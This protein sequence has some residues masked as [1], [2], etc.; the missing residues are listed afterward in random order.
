MTS[1]HSQIS[2]SLW[3]AGI[4]ALA[5]IVISLGYGSGRMT[6]G[7][8]QQAIAEAKHYPSG[9]LS[10]VYERTS[11]EKNDFVHLRIDTTYR[12]IGKAA[13]NHQIV[14]ER[15]YSLREF[16]ADYADMSDAVG[17]LFV[18]GE[19]SHKWQQSAG[20]RQVMDYECR[21]AIATIEGRRYEVWYTD[22]LP[23]STRGA[24]E[25]DQNRGLILEVYSDEA[26]YSL[27]IKNV[28]Q[29]IG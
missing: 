2:T 28:T 5:S 27:R 19:Q 9:H 3:L 26:D 7:R 22:Q 8:M 6:M 17:A 10:I 21:R 24:V 23:Y 16:D 11:E 25:R 13:Y 15:T 1:R 4:I 14:C 20:K 18:E 29:Q 12:Q